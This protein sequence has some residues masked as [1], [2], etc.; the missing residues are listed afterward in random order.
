MKNHIL[1]LLATILFLPTQADALIIIPTANIT[2]ITNT[3]A[4]DGV[5]N[6]NLRG[7]YPNTGFLKSFS[8]Q[9]QSL[10]GQYSLSVSA[11]GSTGYALEE[12]ASP[13]WTLT[14]ISCNDN[15]NSVFYY[16]PA[17]NSASI[18]PARN[19]NIVC[20][21]TNA[22]ISQKT[23]VLFIPGTMGTEMKKGEETLWLDVDRLFKTNNDRFMDPLAFKDDVTPLDYSVTIGKV[24]DKPNKRFDYTQSLKDDLVNQGYED[25]I[26]L[27]PLSY[28]WREDISKNANG[29]LKQKIDQI[30][31]NSPNGKIDIIA[32][33]QGGLLIKRL[34]YEKPEYRQRIGKLIF[35]GMPNLGS[36]KSAKAL[37]YGDDMSISLLGL[38][39][40][41]DEIK[42]IAKNMPAVY[43]M[44]PSREYFNHQNDFWKEGYWGKVERH[45]LSPNR[46]ILYGF[47]T[48]K[49][50]LKD[51]GLNSSLVDGID[52]F[53]ERGFD[54]LDFTNSG[55][56][57][58]NIVGCQAPT[59]YQ[60]I[61][62]DWG[63]D[64]IITG[65]G[66]GTVP[67]FSA[68]N[69]FGGY[70]FYL[71]STDDFHGSMPSFDGVRQK[72]VNLVSDSNLPTQGITEDISQC[73][74]G[75]R[76]VSVHSPVE[77][78][79]YDSQSR[80]VGPDGQGGYD[81][82]IPGVSYDTLGESKYAFLPKDGDFSIKL[83]ATDT[84][85]FSLYSSVISGS[86]VESTTYYD[87]ITITPSSTAKMVLN[88]KNDQEIVL[89]RDG[90]GISDS[91]IRPS[92][93]LN[94]DQDKDYLPP[95]TEIDVSGTQ[96]QPNFYRSSVSL[97][98]AAS[99]PA[100]V[101]KETES[102]GVLDVLYRLKNE[103]SF[104]P[105]VSNI[106]L[107]DEGEYEI[108]YYAVDRAGNKEEI[109]KQIITI[110]KTPP[111]IGTA[112]DPKNK[113]LAFFGRDNISS[114]EKLVIVDQRYEKISVNDEA[115]NTTELEVDLKN[116]K[117]SLSAEL[118][119]LKYNNQPVDLAENRLS[120]IWKYEKDGDLKKLL[121][122]AKSEDGFNL[123]G[124][125][126]ANKTTIMELMR[127]RWAKKDLPGLVLIKVITKKGKL[128]WEY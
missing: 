39:L 1:F 89:D 113:D 11:W 108:E 71:T 104:Q 54:N 70:N 88:V 94:S 101:G 51:E 87:S 49:Q 118:E 44:L 64:K 125:Y 30:I 83:V 119:G 123:S 93:F 56:E 15:N 55:M 63:R 35:L 34:L 91:N 127:G 122:F 82:E 124:F 117:N 10:V 107:E 61:I 3:I 80:H 7:I 66:D 78:H 115:G 22:K 8:I 116:H 6:F 99:D 29:V 65:P 84:G 48:T 81:L 28:D 114:S 18:Y 100:P 110:D 96:G 77:L 75:G 42:R 41:P 121:Q 27:F 59:L 95:L 19:A 45:L 53:H 106:M 105:Y 50:K 23:P 36:P 128:K 4:E 37:L 109:H 24:L 62:K 31:Q 79:I 52:L 40:D 111:E 26:N 69:L 32:H 43:Q 2:I 74:Y 16:Y 13:G 57:V 21:V 86:G 102:S 5:F 72:I 92:A 20:T 112:F 68:T 33:S 73:Q 14:G 98:L 60:M 58:Y 76:Q 9:T 38:G 46:D 17:D 47:D 103:D 97:T 90:D 126:G 120:F 12:I 25:G 85:S 67:I